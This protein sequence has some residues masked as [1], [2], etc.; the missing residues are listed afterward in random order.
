MHAP[1]MARLVREGVCL[2]DRQRIHVGTQPDRAR[3]V[4]DLEPADEAGLADAAMDLAAEGLE[5]LGDEVGGALLLEA[6][7]RMRMD[8]APPG[9]HFCLGLFQTV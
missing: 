6:Q 4:A 5:L 3:R 2:L 1:G 9:R 7:L 8:V